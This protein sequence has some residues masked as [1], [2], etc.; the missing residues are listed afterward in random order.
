MSEPPY[1]SRQALAEAALLRATAVFGLVPA[2]VHL[3]RADI[4]QVSSRSVAGISGID[5]IDFLPLGRLG[6]HIIA[7]A[8]AVAIA[9]RYGI[10]AMHIHRWGWV[11]IFG[12]RLSSMRAA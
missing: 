7:L 4:A 10:G 9:Q 3:W 5:A 2:K 12:C 6:N 8:N 11:R 1:P